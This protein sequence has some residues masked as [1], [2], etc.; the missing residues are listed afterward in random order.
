VLRT[1]ELEYFEEH[2]PKLVGEPPTSTF[3][4]LPSITSPRALVQLDVTA[5]I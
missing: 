4:Q 2:A 5:V 3:I 1:T